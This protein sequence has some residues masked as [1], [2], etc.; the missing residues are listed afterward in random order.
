[1]VEIEVI[2]EK[3]KIPSIESE[4]FENNTGYISINLF[5]DN[6]SRDFEAALDTMQD[7]SGLIIDLRD[8]GGGYL[9]SSVEILSRF[10]NQ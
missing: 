5:G 6:T 8:N 9:Q 3:I 4:I 1:M 10:V 2:R 7:S